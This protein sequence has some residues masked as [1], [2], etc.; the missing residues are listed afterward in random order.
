MLF[1][2]NSA[3]TNYSGQS[4]CL[5]SV[6]NLKYCSNFWFIYS[7]CLYICRWN[8]VDNLVSIP[9]IL[10]NSF[11]NSATNWGPLLLITLSSNFHTLSLNNLANSF[12]N[13][14]FVVAIKCTIF[15]NQLHTTKIT[16][17]SVTNG[18]LVIKFTIKYI[19]TFFGTSFVINFPTNAS[20]L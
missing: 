9:N 7:I 5:Y 4:L 14:P 6:K 11:V 12:T 20:V 19:H 16:S 10:F 17:F 2:T 13:V 1:T 3:I 8:A 15:D 18:N